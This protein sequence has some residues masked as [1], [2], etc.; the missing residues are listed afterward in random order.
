MANLRSREYIHHRIIDKEQC[1]T[2]VMPISGGHFTNQVAICLHLIECGYKPDIIMGTSGGCI[3]GVLL[4]ACDIAS[5]HDEITLQKFKKKL[6]EYM[7]QLSGDKYCKSWLD[8]LPSALK[9]LGN[10]SL[11]DRGSGVDFV[12]LGKIDLENQP[13]LWIGTH[14][15]NNHQSVIFCTKS[16][17]KCLLNSSYASKNSKFIH[18][19]NNSD[20]LIK[21]CTASS[22]VPTLVP[23]VE[24]CHE[25]YIDGGMSY[26]SPFGSCM[27]AFDKGNTCDRLSYHIIYISPVRYH[28][29][30]EP[31]NDEFEDDDLWARMSASTTGIITGLHIADRNNG[32]RLVYNDYCK[33]D[34]N[35]ERGR[36]VDALRKAL[37]IQSCVSR[38]FIEIAPLNNHKVNFFYMQCGEA[39][40][41]MK[42]SYDMGFVV[43]HWY[44]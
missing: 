19:N 10:F 3:A 37:K 29:K 15:K 35:I 31:E 7:Y 44:V 2:L 33:G 20:L 9:G 40:N 18:I 26:A 8:I 41:V 43:N 14:C 13:E 5:V 17:E 34:L 27:E 38:S 1:R 30:D 23:A 22:A 21:V 28:K 42:R 32:I 36:G 24:I 11:F 4:L 16:E 39:L 12:D 6:D 25:Y